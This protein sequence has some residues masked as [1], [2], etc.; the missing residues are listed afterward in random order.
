MIDVKMDDVF[1]SE[2]I[3]SGFN[4]KYE[5]WKPHMHQQIETELLEANSNVVTVLEE[6]AYKADSL[7]SRNPVGNEPM[8]KKG[9]ESILKIQ[10]TKSKKSTSKCSFCGKR[11]HKAKNC[12]KNPK[13]ANFKGDN[14]QNTQVGKDDDKSDNPSKHSRKA[15]SSAL[16][17]NTP[18]E[19][20]N[21]ELGDFP[22]NWKTPSPRASIE[23]E[24]S[25]SELV[26]GNSAPTSISNFVATV[27]RQVNDDTINIDVAYKRV[28]AI[29]WKEAVQN[30]L[31]NHETNGTWT[32][33]NLPPGRK[34]ITA[35]WVLHIKRKADGSIDK[36]KARLVARGFSQREGIDYQET[37]SPVVRTATIRILLAIAQH[38]GWNVY[39]MD[40][41][42]AFLNGVVDE[43]IYMIQP[44]GCED[45][46]RRVCKLNKAIYGLKQASRTWYPVLHRN[47][48]NLGFKRVESDYG[49]YVKSTNKGKMIISVYVD[50]YT[51]HRI[52][53]RTST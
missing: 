53:R 24:T 14:S 13:S 36:Y 18:E 43:D 34:A 17:G 33:T 2:T 31:N 41:T 3:I 27:V 4:A 38:R 30:E 26:S 51:D 12:F 44:P 22:S 48:T 1:V 45:G 25:D 52:I 29:K 46:T 49:L 20:L 23:Q 40:V 8:Q 50:D 32:L 39:Q 15:H 9:G 5:P 47:L 42:A 35:K 11:N 21:E 16:G 10:E 6:I 19:K 7:A 28:D 37:F